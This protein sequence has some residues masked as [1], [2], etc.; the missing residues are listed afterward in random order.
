MIYSNLILNNDNWKKICNMFFSKKLPHALLLHGPPGTGK[1]GHAI[2]LAGLV[3]CINHN[4]NGACGICS[5]CNKDMGITN[6]E[7]YKQNL[8]KELSN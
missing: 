1:E 5:S 7:E 2:E 8:L 3:N 6:L 4:K